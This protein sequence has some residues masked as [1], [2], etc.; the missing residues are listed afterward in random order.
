M[1]PHRQHA[2]PTMMNR[3]HWRRS[4]APQPRRKFVR[5]DRIANGHYFRPMPLNLTHQFVQ[6]RPRSQRK[7][8][9]PTRHR[10]DYRQALPSN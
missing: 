10:L 3:W 1:R 8:A 7:H 5:L 2:L 9:K 4:L 6:I